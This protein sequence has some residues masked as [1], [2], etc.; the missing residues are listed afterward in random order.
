MNKGIHNQEY[1]TKTSKLS[2]RTKQI[3]NGVYSIL[4]T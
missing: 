3:F 4:Y 2:T 1:E